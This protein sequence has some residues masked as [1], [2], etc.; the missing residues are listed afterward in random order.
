[1]KN[2]LKQN[3]NSLT[4]LL[5]DFIRVK[6]IASYD[7][8]EG[9]ANKLCPTWRNETWRRSIRRHKNVRAVGK[10]GGKPTG[11]NPIVKYEYVFDEIRKP[12]IDSVSPGG[13]FKPVRLFDVGRYRG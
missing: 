12:I 2:C 9:E 1:M 8:V 5:V 3:D 4:L 6:K 7:E 13:I 10:D 11:N